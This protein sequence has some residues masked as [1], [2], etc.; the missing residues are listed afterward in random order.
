MLMTVW[1][2]YI[3]D[4]VSISKFY[5]AEV[6]CKKSVIIQLDHINQTRIK[7]INSTFRL[8]DRGAGNNFFNKDVSNKINFTEGLEYGTDY[9]FFNQLILNN[10]PVLSSDPFNYVYRR[11]ASGHTWNVSDDKI[12]SNSRLLGPAQNFRKSCRILKTNF[13]KK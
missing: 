7:N 5:E 6:V 9:D 1:K 11:N 10:I 3:S 8:V 4:M 13:L 12:V 2:F